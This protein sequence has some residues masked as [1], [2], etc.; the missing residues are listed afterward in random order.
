MQDNNELG[1]MATASQDFVNKAP[2]CTFGAPGDPCLAAWE[3]G[4]GP[5]V[6]GPLDTIMFQSSNATERDFLIWGTPGA[7]RGYWPADIV[8]TVEPVDGA[9]SYDFAMVK[10]HPETK[11]GTVLLRSADPRDVPDINFHFFEGD[12]GQKDLEAFKEA[13][14]FARSILGKVEAPWGPFTENFPCVNGTGTCDVEETARVQT[15]SHHATSSCAIG[16]DDDTM[17]VLDSEFHVRGT[18]GL[19]VVDGSAFPRTP[20]A[21]PVVPTFMLAEKA[22]DLIINGG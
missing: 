8:N 21:F 1:L 18:K 15:W 16:N 12:G 6:Y 2:A 3:D 7:Y 17:A 9:N 11:S 19:R 22:S 10:I 14:D 13:V 5:Y 4:A 20:G